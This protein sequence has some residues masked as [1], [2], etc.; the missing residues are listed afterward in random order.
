MG[1]LNGASEK[2]DY[3]AELG[4]DCLWLTPIMESPF[5]DCGYDISDHYRVNPDFG[6]MADF[7]RLLADARARG[8][9]LIIDLV[10]GYT[11]DSKETK[12]DPAKFVSELRRAVRHYDEVFSAS[13]LW[14]TVVLGNHDQPRVCSMYGCMAPGFLRDRMA[15]LIAAYTLLGKGT[16]FLYYG[17]EIGME[18]AAFDRVEELKDTFGVRFFRHLERSGLPHDRA[19]ELTLNVARDVCRT[20][21]QWDASQNAGFS[22]ADRTWLKVNP[23]H[24]WKN[25]QSQEKDP[26]SILHFY[27]A[28]IRL[29]REHPAVRSGGERFCRAE[30]RPGSVPDR[31]SHENTSPALQ[32]P[33]E[34]RFVQKL[35]DAP[36]GRGAR[37]SGGIVAPPL[38]RRGAA[39]DRLISCPAPRGWNGRFSS[40]QKASV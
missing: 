26:G 30:F 12:A 2:L 16:P 20:P 5:C 8:L 22:D 37:G 39:L 6:T 31:A 35:R 29:R 4:V 14:Q 24:A 40:E 21:M 9:R 38:V 15:R 27:R 1:D 7:R 13:S 10:P 18:N 3:L 11:A 33:A 17:E 25:V 28:L 19:M 36:A 34:K 23:D 32:L